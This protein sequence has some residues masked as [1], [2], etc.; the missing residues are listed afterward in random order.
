MSSIVVLIA[1]S[2][3][4]TFI[5]PFNH[6]N[7]ALSIKPSA[8][9]T[10]I[11]VLHLSQLNS[12]WIMLRGKK[13]TQ[14]V[15]VFQN[16]I[17]ILILLWNR[18]LVWAVMSWE[19]QYKGISCLTLTLPWGNSIDGAPGGTGTDGTAG[20]VCSSLSS[21]QHDRGPHC[22]SLYTEQMG[23]KEVAV[24]W[25]YRG[26]LI[27]NLPGWKSWRQ[28]WRRTGASI[29]YEKSIKRAQKWIHFLECLWTFAGGVRLWL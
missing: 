11:T 6:W 3:V 17:S 15:P 20:G 14:F 27:D 23:T 24:C 12:C 1:V 16:F 21:R 2:L 5:P 25:N 26:A 4:L 10:A 19:R 7:V 13:N 29:I 18:K 8:T 9:D 22:F 28:G